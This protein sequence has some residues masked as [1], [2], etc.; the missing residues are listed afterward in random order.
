MI[1]IGLTGGIA[2]GKSTVAKML[3]ELGAV[4][5]DA[6]KVG[7]EA[8][9]PHT[10]AWR[11]VVAAFG[12]G[13]LCRNEEIDRSKLAQ[14]VFNDPK[15]LKRL[16]NIMHPLMRDIVEKKIETLR[17]KGVEVAVLEAT[18]LIEAKWTDLVDQVWVTLTP[19]DAVTSRLVSQ[20]GFTDAQAKARIESQTP[21]AQRA[22]QADVVIKNDSDM[23]MLRMR[24][25]ELWR[26]LQATKN[27]CVRTLLAEGIDWKQEV[28]K[29]LASRQ[30]R[31]VT[32]EGYRS[33]AVLIPIYEN[34]NEHYIVLT[35]RTQGVMYHK[36][37]ISFPG[38]AQDIEDDDLTATALREAFEE[39][40]VRPDHVEILGSLDD[41][42]TYTSK[43]IITPFVGAIPYPYKFKVSRKEVE[44]LIE[45]PLSALLKPGCFSPE[46]QDEEGRTYPWGHYIYGN[47]RITGITAR[48]LKQLLDTVVTS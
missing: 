9:R 36:G 6:D 47:H 32:K 34:R 44:E 17:R 42:S 14:L 4:V 3:A 19:E 18:L 25:E 35:K 48:I 1:V 41:Q 40:G 26:K 22:K 15:A 16:N 39:I 11:K 20:K 27:D 28:K 38:G 23:D 31:V 10:E 33:S 12:K 45:A 21:I 46:T 24:V 37:Q 43:F 30:R 5:I 13:M 7:H 29:T 8:F 2:S